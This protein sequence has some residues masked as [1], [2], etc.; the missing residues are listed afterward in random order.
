MHPFQNNN[1]IFHRTRTN[2]SKIC[3]E[4]QRPQIAETIL[5]KNKAEV[6]RSL[7]SNYTTFYNNQ[8]SMV[9]SQKQTHRSMKQG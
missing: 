2:N 8:N 5:I 4:S 9:L 6:S 3:K 7:I 1:C